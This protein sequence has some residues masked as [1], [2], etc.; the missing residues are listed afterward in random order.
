MAGKGSVCLCVAV[1]E[2][3]TGSLGFQAEC[4]P[5]EGCRHC[6]V[7]LPS[8]QKVQCGGPT[9]GRLSSFLGRPRLKLVH[10][11]WA[12]YTYSYKRPTPSFNRRNPK[13]KEGS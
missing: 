8:R 12:I 3:C 4:E 13:P 9:T 2:M 11:K 7:G 6:A 1:S 5:K 10:A